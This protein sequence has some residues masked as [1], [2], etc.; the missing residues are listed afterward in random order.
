MPDFY[1]RSEPLTLLSVHPGEPL[2]FDPALNR[3]IPCLDLDEFQPEQAIQWIWETRRR[4]ALRE[5]N[6]VVIGPSERPSP[7]HAEYLRSAFVS[8]GAIY[9]DKPANIT[10]D[11]FRARL[12]QELRDMQPPRSS[13]HLRDRIDRPRPPRSEALLAVYSDRRKQAPADVI[14]DL[15]GMSADSARESAS[16]G[17]IM[18]LENGPLENVARTIGRA[19]GKVIQSA[20]PTDPRDYVVARTSEATDYLR[21]QGAE[22]KASASEAATFQEDKLHEAEDNY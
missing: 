8:S 18:K 5:P 21:R 19:I 20:R 4:F 11:A 7:E 2:E 15:L 13:K 16:A 17:N 22:L 1:L 3:V 10:G 14:E 9:Y 6:F 12:D